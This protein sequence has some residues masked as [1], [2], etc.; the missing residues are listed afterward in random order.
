MKIHRSL[1]SI[2]TV[3]WK[4]KLMLASGV[5]FFLF[6]NVLHS[7]ADDLSIWSEANSEASQPAQQ[8]SKVS[9]KVT[10]TKGE[11]VVG[12]TVIVK[13]TTVGTTTDIDG[14]Y[15]ISV[16][17]N[18]KVLQFSFI[19]LETKEANIKGSVIN[20]TLSESSQALD[21]VIAIGYGTARRKDVTGAT[22]MIKAEQLTKIPV[23]NPAEAISGR[24]AG[25]Q[26]TTADGSPDAE[27]LIRVRGGG[28][29]TGSNAPLIIVDGFPVDKLSD[30]AT[31]DIE[32]IVVLKDAA[33]T[34]IYGSKGANGVILVSTKNAKAGKTIV[35]YDGFMK[36]KKVSKR[37]PVL[38][39]YDYVLYQYERYAF[40]G[41]EGISSFEGTFGVYDD[42]DL[43]Q[44]KK[45]RD[46]QEDLFGN[47]T[48]S[49]QHQVSLM[50]G[51]EQTKF[52]LTGVYDNNSGL[53]ET[54]GYE[55]YYLNFKLSH[56]I[57][58]KLRFNFNVRVTDTKIDGSGTAGD[59]Y[60]VRT[61]DALKYQPTQGL[62]DFVVPD[63]TKMSD[64]EKEDYLNAAMTVSERAKQYWKRKLQ[65]GFN[66][67]GG[68]EW[69]IT[70]G[71][72]YRIDAG[73]NYGFNE[74]QRY[75]GETT[76]TASY[77]GGLPLVD[78]TK[79]NVVRTR[80][81]QTISFEKEFGNHKFNAM[82]GQEL[83]NNK[84]NHNYIYKTGFST[85]ITPEKIFANL[86]LAPDT[87]S[88]VRSFV[89]PDDRML[90]YFGRVSYNYNDKYL[91]TFTMRADGSSRFKEGNRWGYFPAAAVA[92]RI[93]EE[94]FMAG[95][96][97][98]MSNLKLRFSY[99]T[100][101]NNDIASTMYQ[102]DYGIKNTGKVY[103][104]GD[105][106]NSYYAPTN[107]QMANPDLKWETTI[108]RN[109][110][111]D[112]GLWNGKLSGTIDAY[113]NSVKDLLIE[114]DIVAP[115]YS[116]MYE[117]IGETSNKGIELTLD[118]IIVN[119]NDFSLSANFNFGFNQAKVVKIADGA[120]YME[121]N[122]GWAGTDLKSSADFRVMV[123][124][125]VGV[126]YGWETEGYY[127]TDDFERYDPVT[128]LYVLKEG[129][130]T[131]GLLGG[132]IG[133][134]PGTL[135][136]KDIDGRDASGNLTGIPDG[137]VDADDRTVLGNTTP[138]FSG[139]FG[140]DGRYKNFDF[141]V[142]FSFV[143][144]NKIYNAT[145]LA[146]ASPYRSTNGN[147][148]AFMSSDNA[149]SY[150]DRETGELVTDL[151]R[152][153][154]MNEGENKKEYWSPLSTGNAVA[155]PHSWG[156]ED[157]SYLRFQNLQLGYTLPRDLTMKIA[158]QQFRVF[159]TLNNLLCLTNY[160]GYDPEVS[161]PVRNSS[162]SNLTKGVDY[163]SYPKSLSWT[164]GVNVTF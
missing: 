21:E 77:V 98:V 20:V 127:T 35:K 125:P 114:H 1:I 158:C 92:W 161:S 66:F 51:T 147:L 145:K 14:N 119:K 48:L 104:A 47:S 33:S 70:N 52:A 61:T 3:F 152:L 6:F 94:N 86:A 5:A 67:F 54:D 117:N 93:S 7:R 42:I 11:P 112:F 50:G 160:T 72:I 155:I 116:T 132:S 164:F 28:S 110:G 88:T 85:D 97:H 78:W 87:A 63:F 154:E 65:K 81:A 106:S 4:S 115:G 18:A 128:G 60:K 59:T 159:A 83:L 137:V 124:E 46:G 57:S 99:G 90:S 68:L 150:L 69:D 163:S 74:S 79:E 15:S 53:M 140:F 75:W 41:E 8:V 31:T 141:S 108:T 36:G 12:V 153:A 91:A 24:L 30:V 144:G 64:D 96:K 43:Y 73:Y 82:L 129:V 149:Y 19:G 13:G 103:G 22:S 80:V 143:Y 146:C 29:V 102:L 157:G 9:G 126:I 38:N 56:K 122:S 101:G 136:L 44:Y 84:D 89:S 118:A 113:S 100:S 120:D 95:I 142:M 107:A 156:I 55:R 131:T 16:G 2:F 135:K 111:L 27:I 37:L 134:R 138:K 105:I 26:V 133:I 76:T 109:L 123:G 71:L 10:D 23:S 40:G 121:F 34:A 139:G 162:V 130:P 58:E 45:A 62:Y 49:K 151:D 17:A 148:L 32:D 39:S 25:V